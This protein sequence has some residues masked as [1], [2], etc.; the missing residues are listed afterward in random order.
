M[1]K[2]RKNTSGPLSLHSEH[3]ETLIGAHTEIQGEMR[4]RHSARIDGRV[5]ARERIELQARC[6]V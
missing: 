5:H 6:E 1:F 3:F 2:S 4:L